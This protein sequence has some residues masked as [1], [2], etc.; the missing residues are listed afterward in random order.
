[1]KSVNI[2]SNC[3]SRGESEKVLLYL[4]ALRPFRSHPLTCIHNFTKSVGFLLDQYNQDTMYKKS[5]LI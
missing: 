4:Y 5:N 3:K 2:F 1:M